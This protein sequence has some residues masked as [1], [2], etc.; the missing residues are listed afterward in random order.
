MNNKLK[1]IK[2]LK[3][4]N[5]DYTEV[6]LSSQDAL[7]GCLF[8]PVNLYV[9]IDKKQVMNIAK[10]MGLSRKDTELAYLLH[11]AGHA[12]DF[13]FSLKE[14]SKLMHKIDGDSKIKLEERAWT[15]ALAIVDILELDINEFAFH[16][17]RKFSLAGYKKYYAIQDARRETA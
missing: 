10:T 8:D 1:V 15:F 13:T 2:Y 6:C 9:Y 3:Q 7:S 11:E 17:V 16:S 14:C 4:I 5:V 12:Y